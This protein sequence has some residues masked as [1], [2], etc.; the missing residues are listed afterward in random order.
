[1]TQ[2]DII[3]CPV[4]EKEFQTIDLVIHLK[5]FHGWVD[6]EF[7]QLALITHRALLDAGQGI[8]K[9]LERLEE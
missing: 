1:M 6:L 9:R 7:Y 8:I 5:S 3:P 2:L 4:C